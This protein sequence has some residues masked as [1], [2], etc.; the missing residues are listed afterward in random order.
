MFAFLEVFLRYMM[1]RMGFGVRWKGWMK[2]LIFNSSLSILVNGSPTE[3]FVVSRGL[4][5]GDPVS[6]FLF[7]MVVKELSTMMRKASNVGD[8]EGF[9][10]N[11]DVH[12]DILQ[13]VDDTMLIGDVS[14]RNLWI[15]KAIL[16]GFELVSGLRINLCKSI[17]VDINLDLDIVQAVATFLKYEISSPTFTFLSIL[18]GMNPRRKEGWNPTLSKMR[19]RLS[20]WNNRNL[21]I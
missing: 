14:W 16:R 8:F 9:Q 3:D 18:V 2:A 17:L 10:F 4:R 13:F 12:L 1:V 6:F 15:I 7:L 11:N 5:Q 19:R 20:T 21:S